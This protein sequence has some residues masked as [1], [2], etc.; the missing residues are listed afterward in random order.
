MRC[1]KII[2]SD[3]LAAENPFPVYRSQTEYLHINFSKP[4]YCC[5]IFN[6][7]DVNKKCIFFEYL[8]LKS[9]E[10]SRSCRGN[11]YCTYGTTDEVRNTRIG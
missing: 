1:T 8:L 4:H 5:F 10:I 2:F 6:K 7:R 11:T 9:I 3:F